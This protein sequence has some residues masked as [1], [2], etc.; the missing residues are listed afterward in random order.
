L[1]V[2]I[3]PQRIST[4]SIDHTIGAH[5]HSRTCHHVGVSAP[6]KLREYRRKRDFTRT[7]EPAGKARAAPGRSF[8]VQKHAA[9]R[10]HY[11]F[12][13]E[14][15]GVLKSWAIPKGPSLDP[16]DKR[17]AMQTE[18]HPVEY[19]GFEG[20]IPEGEYG[21]G[22]V[23]VWDRGTWTPEGD[24]QVGL[25]K[26]R[27]TFALE[28][29]K[30]R[31]RWHLVRLAGR[32]RDRGRSWMLIKSGDD[33]ARR[34]RSQIVDDQPL[35]VAT[36]R[37]IEEIAADRD[38]VWRSNR[39]TRE[40]RPTSSTRP[41]K[42][43]RDTASS[44]SPARA[45]RTRARDSAAPPARTTSRSGTTI[46]AGVELTHPDRVLYPVL[47]LT[48]LG[49]ARFYESIADWILPHLVGRP[50]TLVRC[51][52]GMAKPCFYQKH[53][54]WWAPTVLRRVRIQE[55]RKVGEY[56]VV[57]DLPALIGLVQ[58]GILEIHTWNSTT[59]ALEQPDRVVFDLDPADDV[60]W[61]AVVTA[62]Q[63]VRA[64]L[65]ALGLES[66]VKTTGGKG[67]HVVAP[68]VPGPDWPVCAAFASDFAEALER[69]APDAFVAT[70]SKARRRGRIFVDHLRNVRGSTSVA[71]YSTRAAEHAP[72]STPLAWDELDARTRSDR[73]TVANVGHRLRSLRADPWARYWTLRQRLPA[74]RKA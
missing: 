37:R 32:D 20:V 7:P 21:G 50:T 33:E 66:F 29:R 6:P 8:V 61:A 27:L 23:L 52:E 30:L 25:R 16:A 9:S 4:P 74:A 54:G 3:A 64:R 48:K 28:G 71:A 36:G 44:T 13:L 67:L 68:L 11:D 73:Y 1:S 70:M 39:A 59:E 41:A 45:G 65:H 49:L 18:D 46:V 17:L 2:R 58:I 10:L 51:P 14:L 35:S 31:G 55:K 47:G 40:D 22:T 12:R 38:R 60:P 62:A 42:G 34:T 57:D 26:G 19:G 63:I 15:D 56:L 43:R 24:P 5:S 69:E 53:T 72:V